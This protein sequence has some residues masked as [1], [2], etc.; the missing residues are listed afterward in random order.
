MA[1][2]LSAYDR[3]QQQH[4]AANQ[5]A[6]SRLDQVMGIYDKIA[7][8]F[9]PGGDFGKGF[10]AIL[11]GTKEDFIA[12]GMAHAVDAGLANTLSPADLSVQFEERHGAAQRLSAL[13]LSTQRHAEALRGKAGVIERVEDVGPD[14]STYAGLIRRA[15]SAPRG[16]TRPRRP[17]GYTLPRTVGPAGF[18]L[19][20]VGA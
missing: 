8:K 13:D 17:G 9:A 2:R 15:S 18:G 16:V 6:Q 1:R 19:T 11:Q 14:L 12:S 4:D 5:A 20:R 3:I 10:E 7:A